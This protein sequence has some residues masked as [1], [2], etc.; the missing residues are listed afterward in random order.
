MF[1]LVLVIYLGAVVIPVAIV[2]NFLMILAF[3]K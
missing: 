2:M 3:F 1:Q